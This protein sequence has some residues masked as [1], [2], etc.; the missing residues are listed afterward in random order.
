MV[1]PFRMFGLCYRVGMRVPL[2]QLECRLLSG[3]LVAAT[4]TVMDGP[5]NKCIV[6]SVGV[7]CSDYRETGGYTGK[8]YQSLIMYWEWVYRDRKNHLLFSQVARCTC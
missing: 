6:P 2:R 4:E 7:G 8:R 1:S 5:R 3:V